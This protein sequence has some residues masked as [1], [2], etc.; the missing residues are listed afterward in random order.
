MQAALFLTSK[1][2]VRLSAIMAPTLS[3]ERIAKMQRQIELL[4]DEEIRFQDEQIIVTNRRIIGNL[5]SSST[6]KFTGTSLSEVGAPNKFN[7]GRHGRKGLGLRLMIGGL[8]LIMVEVYLQTQFGL[9]A[10]VEA[11][12]FLIGAL[13]SVIG[14]YLLLNSLFRPAPNTTII[15]PLLEGDDIIVSYPEWDNPDGEELVRRFARAK[16]GIGR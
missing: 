7:G 13:A 14:L 5:D 12:V 15:F 10:Q 6:G 1:P 2:H 16:R 3:M 8:A 11:A 4:S 9:N